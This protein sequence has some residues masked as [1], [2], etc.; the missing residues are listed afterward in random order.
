MTIREAVL[1]VNS[2]PDDAVIYGI[3]GEGGWTPQSQCILV[4]D[5]DQ[6]VIHRDGTQYRYFLEVELVREVLEGWR[7]I[8][9]RDQIPEEEQVRVVI[10]YA[11]HD[12]WPSL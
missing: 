12:S 3:R 10:Y 9:K 4:E 7:D 11:M 1:L 8:S 6:T 2:L 5:E